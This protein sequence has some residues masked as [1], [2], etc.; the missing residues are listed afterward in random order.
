MIDIPV[1][2]VKKQTCRHSVYISFENILELSEY[3]IKSR[4]PICRTQA[5]SLARHAQFLTVF[6][7]DG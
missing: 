7:S 1:D 3:A 5:M 2:I 6:E 4:F